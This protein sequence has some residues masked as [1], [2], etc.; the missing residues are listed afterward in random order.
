MRHDAQQ[1]RIALNQTLQRHW[2][3]LLQET[4][5]SEFTFAA[6]M[7][8]IYEA[9]VREASRS[10]E[11]SSHPD[12]YQRG[13]RD[14]ERVHRWF[15]SDINAR[16]PVEA[17]EAFVAAFPVGRRDDL[18]AEMLYRF[19]YLPVRIPESGV[20]VG[21]LGRVLVETGEA[22]SAC[23]KLYAD[24]VVNELDRQDAPHTLLQIEQAI[25]ALVEV[26]A[27]VKSGLKL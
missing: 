19:G 25:A 14:A 7:R 8:E 23:G 3:S 11:W 18:C 13:K 9:S 10:I 5:T 6:N 12:A 24:G 15:S 16:F 17:L 2:M 1:G 21:N 27:H 22:I 26:H 4:S 20:S